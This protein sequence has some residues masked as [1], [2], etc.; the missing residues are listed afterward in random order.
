M[1]RDDAPVINILGDQVALGP[2]RRDLIP[3]YTR[4]RNDFIVGRTMNYTP[5]SG[6]TLEERSAWFERA[7]RDTS[8]I[9]FTI[10]EQVSWRAIGI[11]NLHDIDILHGTAEFGLMI[12]EAAARGR[13]LGTETTRLML[14]YAFVDLSLHNV[15]LR[16]YA[17]N[18]AGIRAYRKAGFQEFGRRRQSHR[19][20]DQRWDEVYMQCRASSVPDTANGRDDIDE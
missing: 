18:E 8:A 14:D 17:Y 9:R 16:V 5:G 11:T 12:G 3:T 4:W 20:A 1:Q 6:V 13:G 19:L 10:Y 15:M 2:L 7:S